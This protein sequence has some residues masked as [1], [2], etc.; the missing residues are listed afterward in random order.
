MYINRPNINSDY[1]WVKTS[2]HIHFVLPTFNNKHTS[3]NQEK[4][5]A[6]WEK[7]GKK[8]DV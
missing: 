2:L 1:L 3:K 5:N 7:K 6:T 8:I 4:N